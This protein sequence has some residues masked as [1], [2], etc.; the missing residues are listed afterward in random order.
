MPYFWR[1]HKILN[2]S[3]LKKTKKP[4]FSWKPTQFHLYIFS[5]KQIL[6]KVLIQQTFYKKKLFLF[7]K[8]RSTAFKSPI[9]NQAIHKTKEEEIKDNFLIT[10]H[11]ERCLRIWKNFLFIYFHSTFFTCSYFCF[12]F[13]TPPQCQGLLTNCSFNFSIFFFLVRLCDFNFLIFFLRNER[14]LYTFY[15]LLKC[16]SGANGDGKSFFNYHSFSYLQKFI[17]ECW[18]GFGNRKKIAS[19]L[20][21]VFTGVWCIKIG[22]LHEKITFEENSLTKCRKF[23][24]FDSQNCRNFKKI[25]TIYHSVKIKSALQLCFNKK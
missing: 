21:D 3:H 8:V 25:S 6:W 4:K 10:S 17:N 20:A 19:W 14:T 5:D 1:N 12:L 23:S 16:W 15:G 7:L 11:T 9:I 18:K 22:F 13:Q 2:F 24:K